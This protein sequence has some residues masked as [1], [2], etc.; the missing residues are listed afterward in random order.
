LDLLDFGIDS[1]SANGKSKAQKE[2]ANRKNKGSSSLYNEDDIMSQFSTD[3]DASSHQQSSNNAKSMKAPV[4][5]S[6]GSNYYGNRND[7][8]DEDEYEE[9]REVTSL[10]SSNASAYT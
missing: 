1:T 4:F 5:T 9:S 8:K 2:V 6:T 10:L 3:N 7:T